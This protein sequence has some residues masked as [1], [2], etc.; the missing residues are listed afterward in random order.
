MALS[1]DSAPNSSLQFNFLEI[2]GVKPRLAAAL[3]HLREEEL[4]Q[5]THPHKLCVCVTLKTQCFAKIRVQLVACQEHKNYSLRNLEGADC[6]N[7]LLWHRKKSCKDFH[8]Y[9]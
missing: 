6:S 4:H 8:N 1:S 7:L 3:R 2:S 9:Y 5:E